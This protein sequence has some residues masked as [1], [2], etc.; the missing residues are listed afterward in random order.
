MSEEEMKHMNEAMKNY[1]KLGMFIGG[2]DFDKKLD[3]FI[4]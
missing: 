2:T 4:E 3:A 1:E